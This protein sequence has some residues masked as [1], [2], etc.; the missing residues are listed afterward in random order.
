MNVFLVEGKIGEVDV[1]HLKRGVKGSELNQKSVKKKWGQ[2]A[3][4]IRVKKK[5]VSSSS[6][7]RQVKSVHLKGQ[8]RYIALRSLWETRQT[9]FELKFRFSA[10]A[11]PR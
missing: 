2:Y 6:A 10:S 3:Y 1:S 11:R 5:C 4:C 7:Q 9:K 8:Q